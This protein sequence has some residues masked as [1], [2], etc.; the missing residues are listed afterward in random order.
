METRDGPFA[1]VNE[2]EFIGAAPGRRAGTIMMRDGRYIHPLELREQ[3]ITIDYMLHGL[4]NICRFTGTLAGAK[5]G[6]I[7]RRV[8]R[9]FYNRTSFYSVAQHQTLGARYFLDIGEWDRAR[10][11]A[12][13]DGVEFAMGDVS[14]PI[15]HQPEMLFY[16][17][18]EDRGLEILAR[19]F[20]LSWPMPPEIKHMDNRMLATEVRDL[21]GN[22][23]WKGL[24]EPLALRIEPWT[25]GRAFVEY[26]DVLTEL[27]YWPI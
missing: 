27:G 19:K 7:A 20:G 12:V 10:W 13:H 25:P 18:A 16:R 5:W 21:M 14:R 2:A 1:G 24:P 15:K 9:R 11:F 4:P 22:A 6:S 23:P 3:D 17:D 8:W 26:R